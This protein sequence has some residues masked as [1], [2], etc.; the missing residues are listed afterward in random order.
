VYAKS[1][2]IDEKSALRQLKKYA[3][4]EF[5]E[6]DVVTFKATLESNWVIIT[7]IPPNTYQYNRKSSQI[8]RVA[9]NEEINVD[10]LFYDYQFKGAQIKDE[11][12]LKSQIGKAFRDKLSEVIDLKMKTSLANAI[13]NYGTFDDINNVVKLLKRSK[14][15]PKKSHFEGSHILR[16]LDAFVQ[17]LFDGNNTYELP[18]DFALTTPIMLLGKIQDKADVERFSRFKKKM[19]V[20]ASHRTIFE[21]ALTGTQL[22]GR[23]LWVEISNEVKKHLDS[24][25]FEDFPETIVITMK[26]A[27]P[28]CTL[29]LESNCDCD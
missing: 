22:R 3:N 2:D 21:N 28:L 20:V 16:D 27:D 26:H 18:A 5:D 11:E 4:T 19:G 7:T 10:E 23:E 17:R 25:L 12:F 1:L 29:C 14:V 9:F 6:F 13:L 24:V 8:Q 15:E